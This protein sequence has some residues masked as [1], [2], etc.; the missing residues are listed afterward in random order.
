[1]E[2]QGFA[3]PKRILHLSAGYDFVLAI[4]SD[5]LYGCGYN[6]NGFPLIYLLTI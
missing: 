4:T 6:Y 5:G 3:V 2:F 1:M